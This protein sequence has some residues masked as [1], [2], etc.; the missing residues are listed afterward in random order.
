MPDESE[1]EVYIK[2]DA[3]ARVEQFG[4]E[5]ARAPDLGLDEAR[6]AG[7]VVAIEWPR[8]PYTELDGWRVELVERADGTREIAISRV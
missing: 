6:A 5:A 3:G 4:E 2:V 8:P 1:T 7:S